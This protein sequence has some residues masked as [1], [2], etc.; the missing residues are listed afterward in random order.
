MLN[1]NC[2]K[3]DEGRHRFLYESILGKFGSGREL[4][5]KLPK[6][7]WLRGNLKY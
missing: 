5:E 3:H 4:R 1:C 2:N 7:W 6:N